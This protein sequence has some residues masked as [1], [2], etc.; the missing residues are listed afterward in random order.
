MM[1]DNLEKAGRMFGAMAIEYEAMRQATLERG[2]KLFLEKAKHAMGTYEYGWPPLDKSTI[3]RKAHGD[4]PLIETREMIQSAGYTMH[5][6]SAIVG[7]EDPKMVWHEFGTSHVP[8]RPV[9]GGT[10]AKHGEEIAHK[11][12]VRY[13][14]IMI[15]T[16]RRGTVGAAIAFLLG[17]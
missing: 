12:G 5:Y 14:E 13:G 3:D 8:P 10:I 17:R 7:F 15:A 2:A 16:L 4:T 6:E 1:L 9:I 11:M